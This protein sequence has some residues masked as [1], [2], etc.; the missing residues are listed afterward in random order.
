MRKNGQYPTQPCALPDRG[1]I[2]GVVPPQDVLRLGSRK[3]GAT[4]KQ[5][6]RFIQAVDNGQ[7]AQ[8]HGQN[9][10]AMSRDQY[11]E[12]TSG[13]GVTVYVDEAV[14]LTNEQVSAIEGMTGGRK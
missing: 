6:Q 8:L 9:Y 1:N 12:L 4:L 3:H 2:N 5:F 7:R 14:K 13:K 11:E 10:V